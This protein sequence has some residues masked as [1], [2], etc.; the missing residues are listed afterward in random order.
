MSERPPIKKRTYVFIAVLTGIF[1]LTAIS[2]LL[3]ALQIS[4]LR[5][6]NTDLASQVELW[7]S[8][9]QDAFSQLQSATKFIEEL[10]GEVWGLE[11]DKLILQARIDKFTES[12][13]VSVGI[14]PL[15]SGIYLVVCNMTNPSPENITITS[16]L[17]NGFPVDEYRNPTPS[18][19]LEFARLPFTIPSGSWRQGTLFISPQSVDPNGDALL[20]TGLVVLTLG[21]SRG[22]TFY[23]EER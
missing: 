18:Y 10:Q 9:Y 4:T 1:I 13:I 19:E 14:R 15:S 20:G 17:I 6:E 8:S 2:I 12:L 21:T 22:N 3:L 16:I 23:G 7:Q 11:A 5:Q